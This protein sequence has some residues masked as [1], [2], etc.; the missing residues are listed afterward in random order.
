[1]TGAGRNDEMKNSI[2]DIEPSPRRTGERIIDL[3]KRIEELEQR[4]ELLMDVVYGTLDV[5][6]CD[7]CHLGPPAWIET[8]PPRWFDTTCHPNSGLL[9]PSSANGLLVGG[10]ACCVSCLDK[11]YEC[12]SEMDDQ[13]TVNSIFQDVILW[14]YKYPATRAESRFWNDPQRESILRAYLP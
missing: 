3:T 1:M 4:L 9:P 13:D 5:A 10:G 7:Y 6:V 14:H 2:L 12:T 8:K 11:L